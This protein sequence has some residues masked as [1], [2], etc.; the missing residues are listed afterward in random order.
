MRKLE[1]PGKTVL[2]GV[3]SSVT[4]IGTEIMMADG[5]EH[6]G[7]L[8]D[9]ANW[10]GKVGL[11][12]TAFRGAMLGLGYIA[13]QSYQKSLEEFREVKASLPVLEKS[14]SPANIMWEIRR[15]END[16]RYSELSQDFSHTSTAYTMGTKAGE[17]LAYQALS[18]DIERA[19]KALTEQFMSGIDTDAEPYGRHDAGR[20]VAAMAHI[21]DVVAPIDE[22]CP[23]TPQTVDEG[24]YWYDFINERAKAIQ[25]AEE[26]AQN[27]WL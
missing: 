12:V 21:L 13:D 22:A 24:K 11:A 19:S 1:Y 5:Q 6:R 8:L 23:R 2:L 9:T 18:S 17:L 4:T 26:D 3:A 20:R 10:F 7:D 25:L 27:A 14:V 16:S 15:Q